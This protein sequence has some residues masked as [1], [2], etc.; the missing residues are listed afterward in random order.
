MRRIS[1]AVIALVLLGVA[2]SLFAGSRSSISVRPSEMKE[3]ETKTFS[4][5]GK[6]ITIR[7]EGDTTHVRIE[8]AG[9]TENL[10]ITKDGKGAVIVERDGKRT[11]VMAAP[12]PRIVIDGVPFDEN[13]MPK[14]PL[15]PKH[16]AKTLF[17]CPKDKTQLHVPEEKA[18]DAF[19]CPVDGTAMEKKKGHGFSFYFDDDLFETNEL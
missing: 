12:R 10:T 1:L 3:G 9:E 16:K 14:M 19:K 17:V 18:G 6:T 5:D 2:G 7:R 11:L 8:G 4:D 13:V 15:L